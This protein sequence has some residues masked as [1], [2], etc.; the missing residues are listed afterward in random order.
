M[1]LHKVAPCCRRRRLQDVARGQRA[2]LEARSCQR[3]PSFCR[4]W[5]F[6]CFLPVLQTRCVHSNDFGYQNLLFL[7]VKKTSGVYYEPNCSAANLDHGVLAVGFGEENGE[8]VKIWT[9]S[10]IIWQFEKLCH[11]STHFHLSLFPI[12]FNLE[13]NVI[14]EL[15]PC[16]LL[17]E[18]DFSTSWSKTPG[19]RLGEMPATSRWLATRTTTAALPHTPST[20]WSPTPTTSSKSAFLCISSLKLV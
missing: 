17:F 8:K 9:L 15:K 20:P 3:G 6:K 19:Q 18:L 13:I 12:F 5:R 1:P 7:I 10:N 11:F 2:R 4:H 14:F 16:F